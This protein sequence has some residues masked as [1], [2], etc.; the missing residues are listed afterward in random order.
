MIVLHRENDDIVT[1]TSSQNFLSKR[2][3]RLEEDQIELEYQIRVLISKPGTMPGVSMAFFSSRIS[4]SDK[5]RAEL[6][7][8][9]LASSATQRTPEDDARE[10]ELIH[11]LVEIVE[12]RNEI[13][14]AQEIDRQRL[15]REDE[16]I[17]AQRLRMTSRGILTTY[18][19]NIP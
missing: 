16:D 17:E 3:Q 13:V 12:L 6:T 11:K 1:L 10:A 5:G 15:T 2:Y 18:S 8:P 9:T 7:L 4:V 19:W 14:D